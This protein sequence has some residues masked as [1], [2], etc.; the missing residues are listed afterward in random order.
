MCCFSYRTPVGLLARLFER[1]LH[2]SE[3]RI[4]ARQ[5]HDGQALAYAMRLATPTDVAMVLPLPV[6]PR[7]AEDALRFV[8]LEG[9]ASLFDDLERGF[10]MPQV[11]ARGLPKG[12]RLTMPTLKVHS[13]G[14]FEASFVPTLADFMRLDERFRLPDTVWS[15]LPDYRDWGFA[16]FKLKKGSKARIHPMAFVFQ[17]RDPGRLFFPTIHVHDG[18]VHPK[19]KFDHAL[20]FQAEVDL[21]MRSWSNASSFVAIDRTKGLVDGARPVHQRILY[22]TL[23][24]Q[25]TW[26]DLRPGRDHA[27][28]A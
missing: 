28:V 5:L 8:D 12:R 20:Y 21:P 11:L 22:G 2:V 3:T 13:V 9:Y 6:P 1:K 17:T 14:A 15:A 23:D 7:P 18:A 26:I 24:N 25:D 4:F 19:A 27:A 16:V 10:T